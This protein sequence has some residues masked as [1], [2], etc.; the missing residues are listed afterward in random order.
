MIIASSQKKEKKNVIEKNYSTVSLSEGS[1]LREPQENFEHSNEHNKK[2]LNDNI[3]EFLECFDTMKNLE[4]LFKTDV[5][6]QSI[7]VINGIK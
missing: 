7:P 3:G 2:K 6:P 4:M 1:Y 5:S